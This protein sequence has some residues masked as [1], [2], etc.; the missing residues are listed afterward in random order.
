MTFEVG[1]N[2]A[3]TERSLV[4]RLADE[5]VDLGSSSVSIRTVLD[6][7]DGRLDRAGL[8]CELRSVRPTGPFQLVVSDRLGADASLAVDSPVI[9]VD[10]L[11]S[12]LRERLAVV[13]RGRSLEPR[14][15]VV[16]PV[17]R[18]ALSD[19]AGDIVAMVT[20]IGA[21]R[22]AAGPLRSSRR[23]WPATPVMVE[24]STLTARRKLVKP[25]MAALRE[26]AL[27]PI[28][29]DIVD[30]SMR[31]CGIS[32]SGFD[33]APAIALE[34]H[35]PATECVRLVLT[36]LADMVEATWVGTVEE[37]D[38]EYLHEFR[39]AAR[40]TR[41]VLGACRSLVPEELSISGRSLFAVLGELTGPA[42]DLDV[43]V[44]RWTTLTSSLEAERRDALEPLRL[45]LDERRRV[46]HRRLS[47]GLRTRSTRRS[48][49]AWR[50]SLGEP[51]VG[52]DCGTAAE[53]IERRIRR[54]HRRLVAHGRAIDL[55]SPAEQLHALRKDAKK[56]RYL[57]E[58][59]AE[60]LAPKPRAK[61]VTQLRR[62]QENLGEYQDCEVQ[63]V[64]FEELAGE[65]QSQGATVETLLAIGLL[66]AG[67]DERRMS[68]RNEFADR[69]AAFDADR[70]RSTFDDM[71]HRAR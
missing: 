53:E 51:F 35:I 17:R 31:L 16:A 43:T 7:F 15:T 26:A 12:P 27:T 45:L 59:F 25:L 5:G 58:C 3:D 56:L 1:E 40:R 46:A 37:R 28:E 18:G 69:F 29:G 65:L 32:P 34:E 42:R 47:D 14:L 9:S 38:V 33:T 71:I 39:I 70:T 55:E 11:A 20:L 54:A 62:L 22:A 2:T 24:I 61:Y 19:A 52:V 21:G 66:I 60:L 30:H 8:R 67:L 50:G 68:A 63:A 4:E 64:M 49:D 57:I 23:G 48:M 13:T 36:H 10:D 41:T 44:G 6:T